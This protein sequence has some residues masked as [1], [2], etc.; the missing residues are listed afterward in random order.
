VLETTLACSSAQD[1]LASPVKKITLKVL[2]GSFFILFL[3]KVIV[4]QI[5][6]GF[7]DQEQQFE[8]RG[9]KEF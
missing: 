9:G 3:I 8:W 6:L 7:T 5:I 4:G 1:A 2:K